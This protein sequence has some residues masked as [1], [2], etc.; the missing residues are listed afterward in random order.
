M[1]ITDR[2]RILRVAKRLGEFTTHELY[3]ALGGWK[4]KPNMSG[5]GIK[6]SRMTEIEKVEEIHYKSYRSD[7]VQSLWRVRA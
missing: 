6:L 7:M 3:D 1:S 2:E 4:N 5:L